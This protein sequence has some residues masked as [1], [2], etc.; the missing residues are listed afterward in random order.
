MK[1]RTILRYNYLL[2]RALEVKKSL[3]FTFLLLRGMITIFSALGSSRT[4]SCNCSVIVIASMLSTDVVNVSF[5]QLRSSFFMISFDGNWEYSIN[6]FGQITFYTDHTN[7]VYSFDV[8]MYLCTSF[9]CNFTLPFRLN[10]FLHWLHS[11]GQNFL[12]GT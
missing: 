2:S 9:T 6:P 1:V 3:P 11:Q 4:F 10:D 8:L 12:C 7:K 5:E